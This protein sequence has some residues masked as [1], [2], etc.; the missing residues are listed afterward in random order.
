MA[1][2]VW[3]DYNVISGWPMVGKLELALPMPRDDDGSASSI[4]RSGRCSIERDSGVSDSRELRPPRMAFSRGEAGGPATVRGRENRMNIFDWMR[5]ALA[6]F[7]VAF[8]VLA[9]YFMLGNG[10]ASLRSAFEALRSLFLAGPIRWMALGVCLVYWIGLSAFRARS[11]QVPFWR[12]RNP[13]VWLSAALIV[14]WLAYGL[15]NQN[16][17]NWESV[18][19]LFGGAAIGKLVS[20]LVPKQRIALSLGAIVMMLTA[21]SFLRGTGLAQFKYHGELRW[22]G[23]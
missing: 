11:N 10:P 1:C 6:G 8:A 23:P 19:I 4:S 20:V 22:M 18:L 5:G 16:E 14:A 7:A 21:A 17:T 13:D 2:M 15:C 3:H 12:C 9:E